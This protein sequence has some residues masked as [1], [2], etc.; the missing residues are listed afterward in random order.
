MH[1]FIALS[2]IIA[3]GTGASASEPENVSLEPEA[4]QLAQQFVGE[5]K[6]QLK[7]A[8]TEGG[9]TQAIEVCAHVAPRIADALTAESGWLTKRV[10]LK[11]RNASRAQPDKWEQAVLQQFDK[12]QAAGEAAADI[13]YGE[14]VSGQYRY[15]QAQGVEA[16]CLTCHGQNLSDPVRTTLEKY[17]PDDWATGYSLGQVR[18][19]ISLSKSL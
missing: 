4:Q 5:L 1:R 6:P 11:S 15:M 18:G 9:A 8:M 3:S 2:L 10:S 12:R 7:K 13:H 19:A 16:I 14:T 17:Y